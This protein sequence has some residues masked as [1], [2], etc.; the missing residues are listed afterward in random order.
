MVDPDRPQMTIRRMRIACC[1]T[2][3]TDIHSE[4]VILILTENITI[5]KNVLLKE[6]NGTSSTTFYC[7]RLHVSTLH[8]G[9]LQDFT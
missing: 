1:V 4:C 5:A 6:R 3:A 2:K 9:H 8:A 7:N